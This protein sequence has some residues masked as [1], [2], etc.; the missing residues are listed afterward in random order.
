MLLFQSLAA[1]EHSSAATDSVSYLLVVV[2]RLKNA[3]MA[4]MRLDVVSYNSDIS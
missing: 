3:L 4:V 1:V 2:I